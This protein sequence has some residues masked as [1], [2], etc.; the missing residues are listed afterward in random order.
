MDGISSLSEVIFDYIMKYQ[1]VIIVICDYCEITNVKLYDQ[2]TCG[3]AAFLLAERA[4]RGLDGE[5][6]QAFSTGNLQQQSCEV[7]S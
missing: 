7:N 5:V 2:H 3:N 1:I 4:H 6:L